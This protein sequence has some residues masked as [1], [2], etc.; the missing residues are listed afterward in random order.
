MAG[1]LRITYLKVKGLT[2][3]EVN[4]K[5]RLSIYLW[6]MSIVRICLRIGGKSVIRCRGDHPFGCLP[7]SPPI[8]NS[9]IKCMWKVDK[10]SIVDNEGSTTIC[11]AV[12]LDFDG[13]KDMVSHLS[14]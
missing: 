11:S 12:R 7:R 8:W 13:F 14:L 4:M 3:F 6:S 10:W 9:R 2:D 5:Y 1:M